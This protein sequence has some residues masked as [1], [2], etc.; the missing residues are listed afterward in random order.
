MVGRGTERSGDVEAA[1]ALRLGG[2]KRLIIKKG[3][4]NCRHFVLPWRNCRLALL[5]GVCLESVLIYGWEECR[6]RC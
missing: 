5:K 3:R 6:L 4:S 2:L 1:R